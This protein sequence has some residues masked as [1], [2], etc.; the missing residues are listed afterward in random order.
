MSVWKKNRLRLR[1][2]CSVYCRTSEKKYGEENYDEG[3]LIA[4]AEEL[5]DEAVPIS[6]EGGGG[7]RR[8][9]QDGNILAQIFKK[10][11]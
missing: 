4:L 3:D 8:Y 11:K 1:T 5:V 2:K 10:L 9:S 7:L 6:G